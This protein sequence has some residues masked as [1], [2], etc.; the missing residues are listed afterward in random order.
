MVAKLLEANIHVVEP[1]CGSDGMIQHEGE[2]MGYVLEGTL[3]LN[4]AGIAYE[5]Q[6]NSSF[7]FPSHLPHGYR[8]IGSVSASIVWINTPPTF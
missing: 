2:E 6:A 1:G 3:E 7:F 4:V 5:I 8:N